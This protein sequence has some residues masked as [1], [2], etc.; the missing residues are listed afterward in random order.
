MAR[1]II[2]RKKLIRCCSFLVSRCLAIDRLR[3]APGGFDP[4]WCSLGWH[5]CQ[6]TYFFSWS[7]DLLCRFHSKDCL[8]HLTFKRAVCL[9][10][11]VTETA[12]LRF[13]LYSVAASRFTNTCAGIWHVAWFVST[14]F[15]FHFLF[16]RQC[17][18]RLV[19]ALLGRDELIEQTRPTSGVASQRRSTKFLTIFQTVDCSIE[20]R[21]GPAVDRLHSNSAEPGQL[22]S[23]D[24]EFCNWN[25]SSFL[26]K[27]I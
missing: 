9:V 21:D 18:G 4:V 2:F 7:A 1:C 22:L 13:C 6:S 8:S 15:T 11:S 3:Q 5:T 19:R 16:V 20:C 26:K 12:V 23:V 10:S 17:V 27:S 24:Q 25:V 14:A